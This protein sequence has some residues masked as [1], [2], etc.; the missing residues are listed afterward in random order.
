[1]SSTDTTI[2][3]VAR[4][5]S[6]HRQ[7]EGAGFVVRRPFPSM[8]LDS[9]DPFLLIDEMGP[10]DYAPGEA[11]GA[12]DHPHRGFETV[13]YVLEGEMEHEDSAGHRGRIGPGDV[14]WMTAGAG[15][16]HSEEPSKRIREQG[17]RL[18][19]FQIWV[20]LPK[21][22]KMTR[23]RYQEITS[24]KLPV[25]TT[26]DGLARVRVVAGEA[27]GVRAVIDTHTPIVYQDWSLKPGADATVSVSSE[28]RAMVY[29][30]E[31][32]VQ[33]GANKRLVEE[34][35]LA[36]LEPGDAV[37]LSGA[38]VPGRLLL[39]AGVPIREPVARHG[40]F[41][42]NTRQELVEAFQDFQ[43]G[44]MG[45]ITRTAEVLGG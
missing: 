3:E 16:I 34:G 17:G 42:M 8:N 41:V 25:A 5:T 22:L 36:I 31:G 1:M 11:I 20:N 43:S 35:Q 32:A 6:S 28:L 7:R 24:E 26:E 45:E 14:Q 19:G 13:T 38:D 15:I 30:F 33:V 40:P 44:R 9:V 39:L 37:R 27:L 23:P 4:I 2:R 29:V 10:A 18:H 21:R 12:P